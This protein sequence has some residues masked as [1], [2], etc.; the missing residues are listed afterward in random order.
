MTEQLTPQEIQD[1]RDI[2]AT[3]KITAVIYRLARGLDRADKAL[4]TSCFH[5]D[6]TDDH[7]LFTGPASEFC[8]W[9]IG[10]L[11]NYERTQ[12]FI[13]NINIVVDGEK[14]ATEAYFF[15]HHV[16]PGEDGAKKDV[17]AA[18]RYLDRFEKRDGEWRITHRKALYDW[19]HVDDSKDGWANPPMS[20]ILTRGAFK[21]Q[22][23][24]PMIFWATSLNH[25]N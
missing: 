17:I 21:G 9:V 22:K 5:D 25:H 14:A 8:D 12:H 6:A 7:G 2:I 4:L 18:G 10:Q 3:Q 16:V 11:G 15:A 24:Y 19:S 20:E 13:S 1:V 23:I